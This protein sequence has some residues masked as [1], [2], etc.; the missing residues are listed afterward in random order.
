[1]NR[2][3]LIGNGFDLAHGLKTSFN[4][5]ISDYFCNAINT[6]YNDNVYEDELLEISWK[7]SHYYFD[8]I[9]KLVSKLDVYEKADQLI[10]SPNFN[11]DFKSPLL[12][13]VFNKTS[14]LKWVDLEVEFFNLLI[15]TKNAYKNS[16]LQEA[17]QKLNSQ[18]EYL[19]LKLVDYLKLQ[20]SSFSN[21]FDKKPLVKCFTDKIYKHEI[22]TT[23]LEED[24]LPENIYF[25]NFNYTNTF[26]DYFRIVK[27]QIPSS[28]NYIHGSLSEIHGKPIFGFGDEF[29]KKYLEFEDEKNNDLFK[30][31][32]SFEYLRT[33]NYYLL[34]RFIEADDFQVQIFGH[35][36]GVSD[37]TM[38]NQIFEHENCKSI[39]IFYYKL[40]EDFDD[41]TDKT[42]EISRHF[43]DKGMLRKKLIPRDLSQEMPQPKVL[44]KTTVHR[45]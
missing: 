7:G 32:K 2:L 12:R 21:N 29:D 8:K 11:F 42:Y 28:F 16:N 13:N 20:E 10:K 25:L 6:F 15:A 31:I 1:M 5:F 44:S 43:K 3:I 14:I 40:N 17:I 26:E 38:L 19:K 39:K 30:H 37:R 35:S 23:N 36:C 33:K 34:T 9:P 4:D 27:K 18:L 45:Q 22:V 24:I 41:F